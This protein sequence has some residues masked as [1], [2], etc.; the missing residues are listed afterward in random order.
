MPDGFFGGAAS[1][2]LSDNDV[3]VII[4]AKT[5]AEAAAAAASADRAL[6]DS[7]ASSATSSASD[8]SASANAA[9]AS[10]DVSASNA[11]LAAKWANQISA[12][13]DGTYYGARYYAEAAA[14]SQSDA[15][16]SSGDAGTSATAAATS[17]T[18]ASQWAAAP[19]GQ[20]VDPS[21]SPGLESSR[22]YA[23]R[24]QA[25]AAATLAM[26]VRAIVDAD[27]SGGTY[28]LLRTDLGQLVKTLTTT[29]HSI[30]LPAGL[31]TGPGPTGGASA[32]VCRVLKGAAANVTY[33]GG[34]AVV[35]PVRLVDQVFTYSVVTALATLTGSHVLTVPSGVNRKLVVCLFSAHETNNLSRVVTLTASNTTGL[36]QSVAETANGYF[37]AQSLL[38]AMWTADISDA[39]GA[40]TVTLA[41]TF[42]NVDS[43]VLW[44]LVVGNVSATASATG[45]DPANAGAVDVSLAQTP[46]E[47]SDLLV[48]G[49]AMP[50]ADALPATL[51]GGVSPVLAQSG[52]TP[53][54]RTLRD[55]S[56]IFG[57]ELAPSTTVQTH[58]GTFA[59]AAR[60]CCRLGILLKPA[61]AAAVTINGSPGT[62]TVVGQM[63]DILAE[64]D[65][66]T[67]NVRVI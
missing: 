8:A 50:G 30:T 29:N 9:S 24:A 27:V 33:V 59:G 38:G 31:W 1:G 49:F 17:A 61:T 14:A 12:T 43:Y 64:D 4:T 21:G 10:G 23:T 11:T 66:V 25:A 58:T 40:T 41:P 56:Y 6:A 63:A 57:Y 18:S 46:A 22:S 3:Q 28:T 37:S 44:G 65:G 36:T 15:A 45:S 55:L 34:S 62:M 48:F 42:D 67:Y 47:A 5:A 51:G 60:P 35:A 39:L 52:K 54:T 19:V 2:S 13:V 16:T 53:G 32:A 20:E 26:P 7:S